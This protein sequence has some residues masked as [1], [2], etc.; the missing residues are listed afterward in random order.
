MH[1]TYNLKPQSPRVIFRAILGGCQHD[2]P[3]EMRPRQL[4]E[5]AVTLDRRSILS[6][7][8]NLEAPANYRLECLCAREP[9]FKCLRRAKSHSR[10]AVSKTFEYLWH[11]LQTRF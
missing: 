7:L 8:H 6:C 2:M 9:A 3:D 5:W 1:T 10:C 4:E 11:I